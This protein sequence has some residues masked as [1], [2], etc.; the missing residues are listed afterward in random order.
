MLQSLPS[1]AQANL[2]HMP[3]L[4]KYLLPSP[5]PRTEYEQKHQFQ[6]NK[7][8]ETVKASAVRQTNCYFPKSFIRHPS[9]CSQSIISQFH[10]QFIS[11]CLISSASLLAS[12]T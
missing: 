6:Q 2:I 12:A 1:F 10:S 9:K 11:Y 7:L 3:I 8:R 5:F 4:I